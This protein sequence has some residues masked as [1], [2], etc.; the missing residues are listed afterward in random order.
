MNSENKITY[1]EL[2]E[3]LKK[4]NGKICSSC[5]KHDYSSW[6]NITKDLD[7]ELEVIGGVEESEKAIKKNGYTE[8]HPDET[9]YWSKDAPVALE[10]YP[11]HESSIRRC[12]TCNALFLSYIEH[13]GHLPQ[14]RLR[15]IRKKLLYLR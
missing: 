1:S 8:Y 10:F 2:I 7:C 9:N 15:W 11:Y 13:S 5:T 4:D 3:A 14:K 6:S 12:N